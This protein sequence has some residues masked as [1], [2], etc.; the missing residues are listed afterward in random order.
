MTCIEVTGFAAG[1]N[2]AL[3]R[4]VVSKLAHIAAASSTT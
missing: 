4:I 3:H 2:D 1:L